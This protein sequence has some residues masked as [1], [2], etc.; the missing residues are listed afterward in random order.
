LTLIALQGDTAAMA[1]AR[2]LRKA[3]W[4]RTPFEEWALV[5][6]I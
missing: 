4:W 2:I 6:Q 5:D 1:T 3:W